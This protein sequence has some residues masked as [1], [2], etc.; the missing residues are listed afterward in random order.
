MLVNQT[1]RMDSFSLISGLS[2]IAY[3]KAIASR[4]AEQFAH[5][6][7]P[8]RYYKRTSECSFRQKGPSEGGV[9]ELWEFWEITV[10]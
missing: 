9:W 8:V 2:V 6:Y 3:K 1:S 5:D 7:G 4:L 10:Q